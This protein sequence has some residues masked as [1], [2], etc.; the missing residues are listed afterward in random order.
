[1]LKRYYR[2]EM[3]EH[4]TYK[5]LDATNWQLQ[6]VKISRHLVYKQRNT[7]HLDSSLHELITLRNHFLNCWIWRKWR[8]I[9]DESDTHTHF[10]EIDV[11]IN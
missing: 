9:I 7:S 1:M 5:R 10:T 2:A 3:E 8:M 4:G 6:T 11:Q